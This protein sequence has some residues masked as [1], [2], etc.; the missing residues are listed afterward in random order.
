MLAKNEA[1]KAL[2]TLFERH[3]VA[4]LETLFGILN[5]RSRMSVFRRLSDAG[6]V[7]SYTHTGSYY[8]LADIPEFDEYG[9]WF[10]QGVGFA[11]AGTL[12]GALGDD[13]PSAA[14]GRT[15]GELE[16]L[17][18]TRL[19]N[20]LHSLVRDDLIGRERF[21]GRHLYVSSVAT[22]S[23]EQ[24][25]QREDLAR[26]APK[27][28]TALSTPTIVAVLVEVIRTHRGPID[29]DTVAERLHAQGVRVTPREVGGVLSEHGVT[30]E[31]KEPGSA[32]PRSQG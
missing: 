18:R 24:L 27:V 20:T 9:L 29:I 28:S 5:T 21:R 1:I 19:H 15:H 8:T 17:F 2:R 32:S 7:S 11:K 3:R 10:H 13:I 12:K 26:R 4:D 6:Y 16:R 22:R 14:A 23:A 31:K 25:A 30:F